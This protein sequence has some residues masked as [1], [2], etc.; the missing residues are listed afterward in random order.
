VQAK[1]LRGE[2]SQPVKSP[3]L[4]RKSRRKGRAPG[5]EVSV[6]RQFLLAPGGGWNVQR[7]K[8]LGIVEADIPN[9]FSNQLHIV[10]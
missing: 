2:K 7:E 9:H 10:G 5:K 8:L 3:T 1:C 6:A 4:R